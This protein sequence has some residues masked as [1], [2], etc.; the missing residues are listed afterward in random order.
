MQTHYDIAGKTVLV[1]GSNRG[2]GKAIVDSLVS[3]GAAKIYAAV[4]SLEKAAP[5]VGQYGDKI[6]PIL[7]DLEKPDTVFAAAKTATDVD[8]VIN[9][10]GVLRASTPLSSDAVESLE[11]E[12]KTNVYG[13]IHMVQAFAPVLKA[14]GGGAFVQLNSVASVKC[15]ADFATYSASKAAAYSITQ[16]MRAELGEQG[17]VVLSVLPGPIATDMADSAGLTELAEPAHLVA[18][19]IIESLKA[20]EFHQWPGSMAIEVGGAYASFAKEVV[21]AA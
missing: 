16:A 8:C 3:N 15:F 9:N 21:E 17:T 5:L 13:L 4:R 20:G 7:I 18:D 11:F 14:N 19:G 12:M 2:I 1:T 6:V 10:A